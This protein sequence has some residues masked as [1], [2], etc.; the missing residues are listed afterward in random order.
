MA[1][2]SKMGA[3]D[4]TDQYKDFVVKLKQAIENAPQEPGMHQPV[5]QENTQ[6]DNQ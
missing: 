6:E 5:E 3:D 2:L 1:L 4:F